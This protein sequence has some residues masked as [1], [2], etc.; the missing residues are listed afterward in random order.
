MKR[1]VLTLRAKQD[2]NDIWDY[3]ADDS[4][5]AADR[6]LNALD[7]AMVKLSK[8]P[9]IGHWGGTDRQAA[10]FLFGL[11]LF[12]RVSARDEAIANC[13]GSPCR[14]R[15]AEHSNVGAG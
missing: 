4:I 2:I 14:A 9:G 6:V 3:I 12:D 15:C 10:P 1:F 8:T 5:E 11:F 7:K 13:S